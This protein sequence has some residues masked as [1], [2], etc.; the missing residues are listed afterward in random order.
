[1]SEEAEEGR[2]E[3]ERPEAERLEAEPL[4][5]EST[6]V[7]SEVEMPKVDDMTYRQLDAARIVITLVQLRRRIG[8]RFPNSSLC[9]VC[10]EL[11]KH[12]QTASERT[13]QFSRPF[14]L[15]R[16]ISWLFV[17]LLM[18]GAVA[19]F[20]FVRWPDEHLSVL[21]LVQIGEAAINDV[22][23]IGAAI[24]FLVRLE[25]R[26]KRKHA[27]RALHELRSAAHIID[28][29]QLTKDPERL[30]NRGPRTENSPRQ[31]MTAFELSRY[32]DYCSEM[33][34]LTGKLAAL[35][36]QSFDDE[37]VLASV[38]EL[39][40]LC[41]GLGRKIWQKIMILQTLDPDLLQT[42]DTGTN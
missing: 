2:P 19:V 4:A 38:N 3:E 16:G 35:Y 20:F 25:T 9:R 42:P 41:T 23:L 24:F 36:V 15:F 34:S 39:E 22:V 28:M 21:D 26:I 1:M 30:L 18:V 12:G 10:E 29:H 31:S 14:Y 17:T 11:V 33:L 8:E 40:S 6:S 32:L 7:P 27:L 37:V 5:A 13:R